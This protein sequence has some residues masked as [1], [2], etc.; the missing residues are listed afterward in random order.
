MYIYIYT[1]IRACMHMYTQIIQT[2]HTYVGT[3]SSYIHIQVQANKDTYIH[4]FIHIH[5]YIHAHIHTYIHTY[6]QSLGVYLL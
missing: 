4:T 6:I 2:C 3:Y 1:Y 5:T